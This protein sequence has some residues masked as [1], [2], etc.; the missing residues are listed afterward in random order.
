MTVAGFALGL[1]QAQALA[2]PALPP[3]R[4]ALSG[5]G[6]RLPLSHGSGAV[7]SMFPQQLTH[8]SKN[9]T[10]PVLQGAAPPGARLCCAQAAQA[11]PHGPEPWAP[12]GQSL[13]ALGRQGDSGLTGAAWVPG[14]QAGGSQAPA[15]GDSGCHR[16]HL[17]SGGLCVS[18]CIWGLYLAGGK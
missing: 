3:T 17:W 18:D 5:E 6:T 11:P 9:G 16:S 14:T 12:P 8:K 2:V 10:E 15:H 13:R 4:W 7:S 1:P